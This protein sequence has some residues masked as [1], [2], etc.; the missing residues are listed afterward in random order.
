MPVRNLSDDR[1][2]I[3]CD[4]IGNYSL[5][6]CLSAE[7]QIFRYSLFRNGIRIVEYNIFLCF[8]YHV[9]KSFPGMYFLRR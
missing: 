7:S 8:A 4:L 3:S 9:I 2:G 5:H 1:K 6:L